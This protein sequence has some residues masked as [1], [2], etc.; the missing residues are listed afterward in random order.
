MLETT[1]TAYDSLSSELSAKHQKTIELR[2][3][4]SKLEQSLRS[5]DNVS[6][7]AKYRE[8]SLQQE[9]ETLKRNNDWLDQ[10]LKT[11]SSEH[12]KFR[13]EKGMR[14]SQ[15]QRENED[16]ASEREALQRTEITLRSHV[17]EV[18]QKAETY[19]S[20]IQNLKEDAAGQEE[21]FRVQ[22]DAANRLTELM[23][24]SVQT[25]KRR[26]QELQDELE[27]S[28]AEASQEIGRINAEIETEH[29]DREAAERRIA[30]LEVQVE[31]LEGDLAVRQNS[32]SGVSTPR[33]KLNG[34]AFETPGRAGS[35]SL[36]FSPPSS[37][38][39]G[40]LNFTQLY[41][42]YNNTKT[43]LENEKRRN[44]KLASTIDD[45][46]QDLEVHRPEI[47]ELR[48]EHAR[49]ESEV[50]EMST[51][52]D[53]VGKDRD[54]ARR[55][56]RKWEGQVGGLTKEGEL[57]RQQLRDLSSQVKVLLMEVN[58]HNQGMGSFNEEERARLEQMVRGETEAENLQ[59]AT[60]TDIF[61][62]QQ[63]TTFKNV[64][65]LQE[66]NSKLLRLTRQLGDQMEGEE[67]RK[68]KSQ[69]AQNQE[70]LES[71]R[72]K[73]DRC[74]DE[75]KSLVTQSQ[76]YIKERD[77]FRR[78]LAHRGQLPG[79]S[80]LVSLSG[81]S[82]YGQ[83]AEQNRLLKSVEQSPASRDGTSYL[84]M[85]KELQ[86]HFD[87][88]RQ[89]AAVD[90]SSLKEQV[91]SLA[92]TN[93]ELRGD[94]AR[95][96][97]QAINTS[98]RYEIL[99][100]NYNLVK[101][102]NSELQKK[103]QSLAESAAKH[104]A[105]T[106]QVA[107]DL[108][109]YKGLLD[110]IRRE[111]AT[112]KAEKEFWKT[113]EKRLT[114]DN[115]SLLADKT[116]L[117]ILNANLQ[118]LLN[119]REHFDSDNRRR[120]QMQVQALEAELQTTKR[121]LDEET[122][123]NKR[124]SLHKEFDQQQ[125]QTRIDDLTTKLGMV[126]EE[127]VAAETSRNYLQARV[128][129]MSIELR[130]A[131]ER[132]QVLL[133][134]PA[135][136]ASDHHD[137][138]SQDDHSNNDN[139]SSD[140][141]RESA[142]EISELKR[143]RELARSQL[144]SAKNQ[145]EQYKAISQSSEEELQSLNETQDQYRQEMD[146][147]VEEKNE[148][149]REV[150]SRI[151]DIK[152]EMSAMNSELSSLRVDKTDN[153]RRFDEQKAS[154]EA[155]IIQWKDENERITSKAQFHLEDLKTQAEIAQQAQQNYE[156]ELVKHAEA[157]KA[158]QKVRGEY[159][160]LKLETTELKTEAESAKTSLTQGEESWTEAKDRYE[161]ELQA[162]KARRDDM[163]AQNKL[164]YQQL[165]SVSSQI[166][167]LQ[168]K[169]SSTIGEDDSEI[170]ASSDLGN[171][172]EII[173]Y[174]RREKEIVDRQFELSSHDAKRLRQQ[175]DY[176]QSQ[177]DEARLKL[178]QQRQ[179]EE[180][181]ERNALNYNKLME[182]LNEL[183][184]HR[185]SNVTL[186]HETRQA[187][188]SLAEKAKQVEELIAQIQPLQAQVR[189]L[190]DNKELQ[191]NEL[192]IMGEDRDRYQQ[193]IQNILQKYDRID[194]AEL[195]GLKEQIATLEQEREET[196][197]SK[198]SMQEQ[199]DGIPGR[200]K[201][202]EDQASERIQELRQKLTDQFKTRSKELSGRIRERDVALQSTVDEKSALEEQIKTLNEEL[203]AVKSERDKVIENSASAQAR[204]PE[205]GA[206]NGSEDGQVDEVNASGPAQSNRQPLQEL[207]DSANQRADEEASKSNGLQHEVQAA[208][209][210]IAE[211]ESQIVSLVMLLRKCLL[212]VGNRPSFNGDSISRTP[213]L[214]SFSHKASQRNNS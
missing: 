63:L 103:S 155:E 133:S 156:N 44:E 81:D 141:E 146:N 126:R 207:A 149:V 105:K 96:K 138:H 167:T 174:L 14:I 60:D 190:Q 152:S 54:Q 33:P 18:N 170:S 109:E 43:D 128:D 75:I 177:L 147:I 29:Q 144:E 66:Q 53:N 72:Q 194:P 115:Q 15:L 131:E 16:L 178:N 48:T 30:E 164:L 8:Q 142:M 35:P 12:S 13:K 111:T 52:V 123:A 175:L 47:E 140:R 151:E 42:E 117:N 113:V 67:A 161:R 91:D 172:Q 173:I 87:A 37:R 19:L 185:E 122:E 24:S 84:A 199:I 88:Y 98:E 40:G 116:Q 214:S 132:V 55:D 159:N 50:L 171:L 34:H 127:F 11:K 200:V 39:K 179:I 189:E 107:E 45:L 17:E 157:A 193:R 195:E 26:Q 209:S 27:K 135:N 92:K 77:M 129:E 70:E 85:L 208:N 74:R 62:S 36:S 76:S 31:R 145:V 198:Q 28:N 143:D 61:I 5:A 41:S 150:E 153:D 104:E 22:L 9:I 112:L 100:G 176:T 71:L 137:T 120:V 203:E 191:E 184:I 93:G 187:Q 6:S 211:L 201:L 79:G 102:Q 162:L 206:R 57:L 186:R 95:S 213:R 46:I 7:S 212:M 83:A 21:S 58:A 168:Q 99:Q 183:N 139:Q 180:D 59:G 166:S 4:I 169:R 202:A 205:D 204:E 65:E 64:A 154:F 118:N 3:E 73:Y 182:T 10:E 94:T 124:A 80:D 125:S 56:V 210:R 49:L 32:D 101:A 78:M 192:R 134:K 69:A 20:Q 110:S 163:E 160:Q 2:Q 181:R 106:Q 86:D 121:K 119:E 89:E 130:S 90:R 23:Q 136:Q 197:A 97:A 114:E 148:K 38:F 196:L 108:V 51:L 158:L 165:D 82:I 188:A 1:S 25:E 68:E